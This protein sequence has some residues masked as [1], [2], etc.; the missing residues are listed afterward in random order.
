MKWDDTNESLD[1]FGTGPMIG[2][3]NYLN[4]QLVLEQYR[5]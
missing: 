3:N 4:I 2:G 1:D 5:G